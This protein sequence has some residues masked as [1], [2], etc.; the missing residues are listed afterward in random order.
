MDQLSSQGRPSRT[1]LYLTGGVC[2]VATVLGTAYYI[3]QSSSGLANVKAAME[4]DVAR[5]P[6]VVVSNVVQG[7]QFR[8]IQLLGDARPYQTTTVF[9]KVSGYLKSVLVDKGDQVTANQVIAEIDSAE[10]E[11]QYQSAVA[12][13]DQK[14]RIDARSRELLRNS[15][16]SQQAAEQ[17]ET[18]YRMAQETVRNLGIMRSYQTLKAPFNGTVVARFADPGALMQ[19]ATTNQARSLPVMQIADNSK[20]RIGIYVEQRDVAAIK[21]GDEAD[22]IDSANPDRKRKAKICRTAGTLD[23]RTRTLFVELDIDNSDQFLV[24]GSF[25]NVSLR[26][27][28]KSFPQIPVSAMMQ[29]GGTQQVAVIGEDSTIKFRPIKVASTDGALINIA[30]GLKV[31]ER[32]GLNVSS[33]LVEGSKV[34]AAEARR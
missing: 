4:A 11:S 12:D 8:I 29:R 25:V 27:P 15:T 21:V 33:D 10:L 16:T 23:P 26:V 24:P 30:D 31:G 32:V 34:R 7:P 6:R 1:R 20:L 28:V 13:L 18:N 2:V 19:A 14:Q 17:A 5:G 3:N 9:A 22:I